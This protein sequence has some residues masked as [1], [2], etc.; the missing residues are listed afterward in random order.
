ML[1]EMKSDD[2]V[3]LLKKSL[4]GL[5][6]AGKSWHKKL[7]GALKNI[8]TSIQLHLRNTSNQKCCHYNILF[9]ANLSGD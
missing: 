4:Y 9:N 6:Q 5:K 7:D 1:E 8:S 2:K 3:W